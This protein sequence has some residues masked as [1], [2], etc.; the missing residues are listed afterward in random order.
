MLVAF[1]GYLIK[2]FFGFLVSYV[3]KFM[4]DRLIKKIQ[5]LYNYLLCICL[6]N[7]LNL[8]AFTEACILYLYSS[9][10]IYLFDKNIKVGFLE[11][12]SVRTISIVL[13]IVLFFSLVSI[14]LFFTEN[15]KFNLKF[16]LTI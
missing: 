12:I 14:V 8:V 1:F 16:F 6:H 4:F 11:Y 5:K 9:F 7:F 15:T 10:L 13:L 3:K 2:S